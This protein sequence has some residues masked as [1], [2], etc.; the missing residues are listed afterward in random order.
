MKLLSSIQIS[1][2]FSD[3]HLGVDKSGGETGFINVYP[4]MK[5]Q[6]CRLLKQS[7]SEKKHVLL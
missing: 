7:E 4:L 6:K 3:H 5:V 2:V 1:C